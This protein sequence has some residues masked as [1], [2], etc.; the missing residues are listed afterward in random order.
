MY[1]YI[2]IKLSPILI[3]SP[4]WTGNSIVK[5]SIWNL[6]LNSNIDHKCKTLSTNTQSAY[7]HIN[8]NTRV[9]SFRVMLFNTD[10]NYWLASRKKRSQMSHNN[11]KQPCDAVRHLS[12]FPNRVRR[13]FG[14]QLLHTPAKMRREPI[15]MI[16]TF[17]LYFSFDRSQQKRTKNSTLLYIRS[18]SPQ[19]PHVC[20][21][22]LFFG[23]R[24]RRQKTNAKE[25]KFSFS[26]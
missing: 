20:V 21:C 3:Q 24:G 8:S 14:K 7:I 6:C 2:F 12:F 19:S 9:T 23:G 17:F 1:V 5:I 15:L 16:M 25:P 11:S 22:R 4:K 18:L 10:E 26:R 13:Y